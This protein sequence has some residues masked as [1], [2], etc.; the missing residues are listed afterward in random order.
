[1]DKKERF[2]KCVTGMRNIYNINK[3]FKKGLNI[4]CLNITPFNDLLKILDDIARDGDLDFGYDTMLGNDYIRD[5][6]K[7]NSSTVSN[8]SAAQLYDFIQ[9]G[10]KIG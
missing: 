2:I 7:Q 9:G 6:A 4:D 10:F 1:M 8:L 5:W 3:I